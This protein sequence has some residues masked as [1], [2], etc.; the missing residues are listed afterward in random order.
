[1]HV[2]IGSEF[3]CGIVIFFKLQNVAFAKITLTY[4]DCAKVIV[5]PNMQRMNWQKYSLFSKLNFFLYIIFLD[6]SPLQN[7]WIGTQDDCLYE[8]K[9]MS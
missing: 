9:Q 1:V 3:S 2:L 5:N 6:V 4:F 8:A 7:H